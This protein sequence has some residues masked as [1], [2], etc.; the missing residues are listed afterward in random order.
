M[1]SGI[2]PGSVKTG[3]ESRIDGYEQKPGPDKQKPGG[4]E[5][6]IKLDRVTIKNY[7]SSLATDLLGKVDSALGDTPAGSRQSI[8]EQVMLEASS[9]SRFNNTFQPPPAANA[10]KASAY[11]NDS[12]GSGNNYGQYKTEAEQIIQASLDAFNN[13]DPFSPQAT[14]DRIVNFAVSFFPMFAADNPD[15]T[16]E[17]QVKAYQDMVEGAI[18]EGFKD[19]LRILGALPNDISAGI[20]QTRSLVSEKLDA[21]FSNLKGA[22]AEEGKKAAS[23]GVWGDYVKKFFNSYKKAE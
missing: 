15:M 22:G 18:D 17:E 11:E 12:G 19:A 16:F 4:Q 5:S 2:D 6:F 7:F 20:E 3:T 23:D 21:F 13:G 9:R 8:L 1:M 10:G 14:A